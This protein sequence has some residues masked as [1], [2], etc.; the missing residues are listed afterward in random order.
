MIRYIGVILVIALLFSY[1]GEKSI[2]SS[3]NVPRSVKQYCGSCH[4][5]PEPSSLTKEMWNES[6]MPKMSEFYIW[7]TE[8]EF[9]YA[10]IPFYKKQGNIPMDDKTWMEIVN[11]YAEYGLEKPFIRPSEDWPIQDLFDEIPLSIGDGHIPDVTAA[12][13]HEGK[14]LMGARRNLY[15]LNSDYSASFSGTVNRDITHIYPHQSRV[16]ITS[17]STINPHHGPFGE[18]SVFNEENSSIETLFTNLERPVQSYIS[19]NQI[20]TSEFGFKNGKLTLRDL[21]N[22]ADVKKIHNLPGAYRMIPATLIKGEPK[23]LV[24]SISQAQE[25]IYALIENEESYDVKE[26][27]RFKPEYGLSD[28]SIGD[29]NND[30]LDDILAVNGDNADFSIIPKKYHGLKVYINRGNFKF[31]EGFSFPL[32]GATQGRFIDANGDDKLDI[33]VSCYFAEHKEN[34]IVLLK[35]KSSESLDFTPLRFQ[36]S[37]KGF[38]M[39]MESGDIDQDGNEDLLLGSYNLGPKQKQDSIGSMNTDILLL[40][41]QNDNQQND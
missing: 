33:V 21:S 10:N 31:N 1:C 8:S 24:H 18:V 9:S 37:H 30:G 4:I 38:W 25:G 35:N 13:I 7:N 22:P 29:I 36:H 11:Y 32:H 19:N 16:Y 23:I 5:V 12:M 6:I 15:K 27:I 28:I 26:L 39:I 2:H 34:S 41:N 40:I 20:L 17:S 3:Q 14:V